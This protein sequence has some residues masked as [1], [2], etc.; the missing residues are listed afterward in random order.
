MSRHASSQV[1]ALS[2]PI[3]TQSAHEDGCAVR[4]NVK[5]LA[6]KEEL[7]K[8]STG[9]LGSIVKQH[10]SAVLVTECERGS[11]IISSLHRLH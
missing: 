4:L 11:I 8:G 3:I 2:S 9:A 1:R 7:Q 10:A 5:R 6:V